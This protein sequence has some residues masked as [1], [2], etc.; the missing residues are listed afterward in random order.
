MR[1]GYVKISGYSCALFDFDGVVADTEPLYM[2]LDRRTLAHFGYEATDDDVRAFIG[3]ASEVEGPALLAAHGIQVT[4]GEWKA[5][6]DRDHLIYGDP[7]L[8]PSPG[9]A[10]LWTGLSGCGVRI[11]VVSTTS[12]TSLV[13]ALNNF[14]LLRFVD[15]IVGDEMVGRHKPDPEP[16]QRALEL[17]RARAHEAVAFDD[18]PSGVASAQAA[19]IYTVCYRGAS[20]GQPVSGA[21][22]Y[23]ADFRSLSW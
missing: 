19:G 15:I 12:V 18:S 16:Y 11:A 23:L 22:A 9:L 2:A 4:L 8:T 21:D 17:L 10:E 7:S 13:R 14:D 20:E 3:K 1:R 6:W 5:V